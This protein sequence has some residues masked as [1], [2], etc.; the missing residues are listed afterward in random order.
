MHHLVK[1]I[2][3]SFPYS[4]RRSTLLAYSQVTMYSQYRIFQTKLG[5]AVDYKQANQDILRDNISFD[6]IDRFWFKKLPDSFSSFIVHEPLVA[7]FIL[8]Y[9]T[10]IFSWTILRSCN[11]TPLRYLGGVTLLPVCCLLEIHAQNW[12][13]RMW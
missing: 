4:E 10:H 2:S 11:Q 8:V 6:W 7:R 12:L 5:K 1:Q 13:D 9:P 3:N